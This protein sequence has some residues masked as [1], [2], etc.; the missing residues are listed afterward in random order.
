ME[1]KCSKSSHK[2][3]NAITFCQECK[4][5][6]CNKCEKLH[7]EF[8]E[9]HHQYK[10]E[11]DNFADDIFTGLCNQNNHQ[12]E[13]KYF[14]KNHNILCC[15]ECITKIK[16]KDHGQHTDCEICPIDDVINDKKN[17]LEKNIKSLEELFLT[18]KNSI[19]ELKVFFEQIEK[20]KEE[21]KLKIQTIFTKIRNILNE[22]EDEIMLKIDNKYQEE[23]FDENMIKQS[24]L[25]PKKIEKSLEKGKLINKIKNEKG[26]IK[27]NQFINDCIIIENNIIS[28]N[29]IKDSMNKLNSKQKGKIFYEN[30]EEIKLF[31]EKIKK[32]EP[33]II[34]TKSNILNKEDFKKINNW[35]GG[36]NEFCLKYSTK[37]DSCDT[38]IFHEK[39]DNI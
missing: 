25:L 16:G 4:I 9:N 27:L 26:E 12:I 13:L 24:E 21:I 14:C 2:E 31:C 1:K 18:F 7:S 6:M 32:L 28:I 17:N 35:I 33:I 30:E 37:R 5:Y 38:N 19:N 3:N 20:E 39:C 10:L 15:A 34:E 22:K 8:I 36:N 11:K 29:K 23:F